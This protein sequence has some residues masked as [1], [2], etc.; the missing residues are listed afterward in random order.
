VSPRVLV[1][2]AS[3]FIGS[4]LVE[5]LQV[6]GADVRAMV[7][8]TS[9]LQH[10]EGCGATRVHAALDDVDAMAEVMADVEV[11][12][13]VAG[14][15]T[16]FG[17]IEFDRANTE[18]TAN[19]FAAA[20]QASH[21]PR[22]VVYVSSL[23][24][25]GPSHAAVARREHHLHTPGYTR[26]GD[27]KLGGE[28]IAWAYA[29]TGTIEAVIVR[30]PLVYGPRDTDVLQMIKSAHAGVIAQPGLGRPAWLSAIHAL[31]LVQGIILAGERG[32]PLPGGDDEHVLA[33][34]GAPHDHVPEDPDH[35]V[36]RGIYYFSDGGQHTVTSF[37]RAAAAALGRRAITLRVPKSAVLTVGAINQWIGKLRGQAP[38]LS[39]DKARGSLAPGWW[40][41][42]S[43]AAH[44]LGYRPRYPLAEGLEHTVAWLRD[45]R[46]L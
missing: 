8:K 27:S 32:T 11:V 36:G 35:P 37:G 23:M 45:N 33:G 18:G 43:K 17:Q 42:S 16:A 40:C 28:R 29:R 15:T 30:P 26:Y 38:A 22:R 6:R 46:W 21:G 39:L 9:K 13:H 14:L 3:G 4:H 1:T 24:A 19:V 12:Y 41:D 5:A 7:R 34:H 44:E 31:D 10:L 25:A 20:T 2:G